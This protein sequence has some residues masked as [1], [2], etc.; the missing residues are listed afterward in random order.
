MTAPRSSGS[1]RWI[2]DATRLRRDRPQNDNRKGQGVSIGN[3]RALDANS[4][5]DAWMLHRISL[6]AAWVMVALSIF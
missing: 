2:E 1:N 6:L 3:R 5:H 4:C